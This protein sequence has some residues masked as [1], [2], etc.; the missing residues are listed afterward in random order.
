MQD[1]FHSE[2]NRRVL[3]FV[4]TRVSM[5]S[6]CDQLRGELTRHL[7]RLRR[8]GAALAGSL[9]EGDDVVQAAIERALAKS[10]Q[11]QAGTRLDSW[12]FKIMQNLWRDELR[13]RKTSKKGMALD[14]AAT[15]TIVDGR[16]ITETMLMLTKT[17]ERFARLPD[18]QRL[19]LALVVIDGHS[20]RE[21]ADQLE[22][23]IGTLMSRLS[24]ARES[25]REMLEHDGQ[26][27]VSGSA[28]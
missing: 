23:P 5:I 19:A 28:E 24:R 16:R 10:D 11:W 6:R 13:R 18:D 12:L 7:P 8:F 17:R 14:G 20:Y 21:A 26:L 25:L 3:L 2:G 22:I 27:A 4:V 1:I 15:D 9:E